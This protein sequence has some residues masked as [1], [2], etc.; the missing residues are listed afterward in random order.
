MSI[1]MAQIAKLAGVSRQAVSAVFNNPL[2]CRISVATQER[3]KAIARQHNYI[4]NVMARVLNGVPSQTVGII[5]PAPYFGVSSSL[6]WELVN[7]LRSKGIDTI[8]RLADPQQEDVGSA[9]RELENKA[10][11]G[12]IVFDAAI[13]REHF[14]VPSVVISKSGNYDV[15]CNRARGAY[16]AT[17]HLISHGRKR[18]AYIVIASHN[19]PGRPDGW[20]QACIDGLG[21]CD[22]SLLIYGEHF[23]YDYDQ[24]ATLIR[25][26]G[27]DGIC[28]QNDYVAGTL[29]HELTRRGIRVPE[30]LAV[31]GFD[32]ANFCQFCSVPISTVITPVREQARIATEL[33]LQRIKDKEKRAPYAAIDVP[34]MLY[35]SASCGC[36]ESKAYPF[37]KI[38]AYPSIELD[39]FAN[40]GLDI[41]QF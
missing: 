26:R 17:E 6:F 23:N 16:V 1:T 18:I 13:E 27:I 20:R 8:F 4:P 31:M 7:I 9:V 36:P 41:S 28:A 35:T 15:G 12:I 37:Y 11:D 5:G 2:G 10:V 3:I 25:Q 32:G 33:L 19:V 40:H 38:N 30:D 39:L 14:S 34:P 22:E 29:I 24:L 21:E